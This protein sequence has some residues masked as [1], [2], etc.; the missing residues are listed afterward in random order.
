[1]KINTLQNTITSLFILITTTLFA[2]A[3]VEGIVKDKNNQPLELANVLL[4][5]TKYNTTTDANGKFTIDTR[6]RLPFTLIVQYVGHQ[7]AEVR[8]TTLPTSPIEIILKSENQL[9]DVVITSRRRIEK[10]QNVPIPISVVGGRQAEQAGAFNVNRLK[11]LV[12]SV[13]LYSS[14]PRNTTINIRGLGSTFGLTNDGI[15]PGVGFY[16]DGVYYARPAA[17]TLDFVDV[18]QIE[19]LRG[20]QGTLFGKNTTAGAFNVTSRK[21]SFTSGANFELS[22]GNYGFIQAKASITGALSKKIAARLSFSG[23]QRDGLLENVVTGKSVNDL[24]N[25]GLRGQLLYT[26]TENTD[27]TLAVDYSK[28]RPDGY[29][30]VVAGV[31]QTNRA[32]YRQFNNIIS[33]LGYSLP[34]TNPFDRKIDHDTPWRSGQ[35]LAGAS[36]N[37]NSK[38]GNGKLTATSA[39]RFWNWDP[40]NDRDFTGLSVL[41]LSQ[42]TS[43]HQQ[44]SQ[45]IRYAGTFL[46]KVTGV[47]GIFGIGQDLKTDPYHIEESGS[48]QWRFSQDS[49]DP[50]WQTAGLFN[51]YGI[52]TKSTLNTV[53]GAIFGQTDWEITDK[54][55]LLTGLRYNYDSKKI[56]YSRTTYGGLQTTNSALLALKKKV[57]SDQAFKVDV[58]DTNFSGNITLAYKLAEKI[59]TFATFANSY[60]PIGINLGG[61]PSDA[62][63]PIIELA[64]VK[65]EKVNHYELGI[66]TTPFNNTTLNLTVF[67]TD[68]DNYQTLV[69]SEDPTLNRGY[70][71]NAEKVRVR[72]FEADSRITVNQYLSFNAALTYNDGKYISFKNAPLPLEETGLKVNGVSIYSKDVSGGNLPG[73]SKWAGT[74]GGDLSKEGQFF[75]NKGRFFIAIDSYSRSSFSSSATPSKYLNIQGYS[76]F[77][78]RVGF[79]ASEGL[80]VY[81]WGRNLLDKNYFEQL[82]PASGNAGH[83]AGVLGDQRTYGITLRYNL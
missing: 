34:S 20:P 41:R 66:K 37:I 12:P 16:V 8:F 63:G 50:L 44:W 68:I 46:P 52:K 42:A 53:S 55:H 39:W 33:S 26:P 27:I 57:Y 18:D 80:S 21:A 7:T 22:Y 25:Q 15:D 19:V 47:I 1:M 83:Y 73:V 71:A 51:G 70:L 40:S 23:T 38:I 60:K 4:K 43:K 64:K 72:G 48:A 79:R 17:T 31:V 74:L 69:Q 29:A 2:Q 82:L 3:D 9:N 32:A 75:G 11:E 59:N 30:Q 36:L 65:P 24:N 76:I 5:G 67:N 78:G 62:N 6:E 45:E 49:T 81:V 13:Q 28:Q 77:N 14:N 35:D 61:I 10:A 56:D 54:L 58:E